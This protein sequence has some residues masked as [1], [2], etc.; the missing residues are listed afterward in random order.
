M[1]RY[2]H[3]I[4]TT[5]FI[6]NVLL[7]SVLFFSFREKYYEKKYEQLEVANTIGISDIDLDRAT[8]QLL[9]YIKGKED[10]LNIEVNIKGSKVQMF[11]EREKEH[12]VDVKNLYNKVI[13]FRS[14]SVIFI[15]IMVLISLG[16]GDY[17]RL[18]YNLNN[19]GISLMLVTGGIVTI[20]VFAFLDFNAFWI[21]FHKMIF[22]NDLWL[23]N[24]ATDRLINMVP[25]PFFKGLVYRIII[26]FIVVMVL[27]YG[28][29]FTM[30][31]MDLDD[32]HSA[33]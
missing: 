6:I 11:N 18:E 31:R 21:M 24:P 22:T 8:D 17:T 10:T 3:I 20:S 26:S 15:A 13:T 7:T 19:L 4:A 14:V 12:M 2:L 9:N 5:L 29:Y 30:K 33:V 32:T 27:F 28:L 23:L 25:E 16:T 1:K